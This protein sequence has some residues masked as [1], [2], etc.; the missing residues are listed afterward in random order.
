MANS[1]SL[2]QEKLEEMVVGVQPNPNAIFYEHAVLNVTKSKAANRRIYDKKLYIKLS[3]VG[4]SD[5]MSYEATKY[6]IKNYQQEYE[7]FLQNRQGKRDPSIEMIPNLDIAHLQELRDFGIL[8]I[9]KLASMEAVPQH[10]EYAHRAAKIINAA[11]QESDN[12]SIEE[13]SIEE[14][15]TRTESE[16]AGYVSQADRPE[17][18]T[19]VGRQAVSESHSNPPTGRDSRGNG[20][21]GREQRDNPVEYVDSWSVEFTT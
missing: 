1:T 3:M 7:Y 5:T 16:K 18:A 11:L 9:P 15:D 2:T 10:L 4:V 13:E 12:G 20:Q 14:K 6:D 21:G 19:D 17:H 8:T